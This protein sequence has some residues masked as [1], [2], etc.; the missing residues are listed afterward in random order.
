MNESMF[1]AVLY[2]FLRCDI[3]REL[4]AKQSSSKLTLKCH[5][6]AMKLFICVI[7]RCF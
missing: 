3:K 5:V 6:V 1:K 4:I 2:H 7:L